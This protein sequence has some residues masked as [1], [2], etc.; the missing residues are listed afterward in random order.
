[1]LYVPHEH[2]VY[3][4]KHKIYL[5]IITIV[6]QHRRNYS[7]DG[8]NRARYKG[9]LTR[10]L[11]IATRSRVSCAQNAS[12]GLHSNFVILKC[13]LRVNEVV[14]KGNT[15]DRSYTTLLFLF[16]FMRINK[17]PRDF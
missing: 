13:T 8:V 10:N 4:T 17:L 11:A 2:G 16:L 15:L 14:G 3:S 1:V 6:E 9:V 7:G 12:E 5:I